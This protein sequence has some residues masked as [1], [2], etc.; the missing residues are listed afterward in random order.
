ML[1]ILFES[2]HFINDESSFK[3]TIRTKSREL[4]ELL[5]NKGMN[6]NSNGSDEQSPVRIAGR[7]NDSE[8]ILYLISKG[9]NFTNLDL[10]FTDEYGNTPL[11][12]AT[13]K[14]DIDMVKLLVEK[15]SQL[16]TAINLVKHLLPMLRN[17]EMK[18]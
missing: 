14:G 3:S 9:A 4:V 7:N 18:K 13:Q 16:C 17:W 2:S 11:H 6:I 5:I 15:G 12:H 10:A 1:K 8:M